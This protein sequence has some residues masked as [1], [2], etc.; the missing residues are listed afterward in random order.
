MAKKQKQS[1]HMRS[2]NNY[3]LS[4]FAC[5]T[6]IAEVEHKAD[7]EHALGI[8]R[9]FDE[10]GEHIKIESHVAPNTEYYADRMKAI[11]DFQKQV[12]DFVESIEESVEIIKKKVKKRNTENKKHQQK[13]QTSHKQCSCIT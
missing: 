6:V 3:G 11:K 4:S 1:V 13:M 7:S 8:L 5:L 10:K 9:L 2:C 12:N